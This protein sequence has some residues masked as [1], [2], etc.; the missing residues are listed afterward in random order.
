VLVRVR[1]TGA[2]RGGQFGPVVAEEGQAAAGT[3]LTASDGAYPIAG[4]KSPSHCDR[5]QRGVPA[6]A[7]VLSASDRAAIG[8][9]MGSRRAFR[10][11]LKADPTSRFQKFCV[12]APVRIVRRVGQAADR[13]GQMQARRTTSS[14]PGTDLGC[15][16]RGNR[17][18]R[19]VKPAFSG[20]DPSQNLQSIG[21]RICDMCAYYFRERGKFVRLYAVF[22][23]DVLNGDAAHLQSVCY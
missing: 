6:A 10:S 5:G 2:R 12:A 11:Q 22:A 7:A 23:H 8:S 3:V 15:G 9:E 18:R 21:S 4:S 1:R 17:A 13:M 19:A 14:F 20:R 16:T